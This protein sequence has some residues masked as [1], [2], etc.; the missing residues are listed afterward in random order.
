MQGKTPES[1]NLREYRRIF[2]GTNQ[3]GGYDKPF[4][5]FQAE[6]I[7]QYFLPDAYTYFHYP[8][9]A[10][11]MFLS[12]TSLVDMGAVPGLAPLYSDKIYKKMSGYGQF[13][14]WDN[15]QPYETG[16][17]LCAWLSGNPANAAQRPVWKDRWYDPGYVQNGPAL[18]AGSA[19]YIDNFPVVWDD[20]SIFTFDPGALYKYFH[21]GDNINE[22]F[23]NVLTADGAL[24]LHLEHWAET[25]PDDS[26]SENS[27]VIENYTPST[28]YFP[29]VNRFRT[30]DYC[31]SLN[32]T[33]QDCLV[34]YSSAFDLSSNLTVA[35]WAYAEDWSAVRGSH[36]V[37]AGLRGAWNIKYNNGFSNPFYVLMN[38]DDGNTVLMS[39]NDEVLVK[40]NIPGSPYP[41]MV[42]LDNRMYTWVIDNGSYQSQKHLYKMDY[43]GDIVLKVDFVSSCTL[44]S[45]ALDMS[46]NP[47]VLDSVGGISGFD[48][49]GTFLT[50]IST[51]YNGSVDFDLNGTLVKSNSPFVCVDNDNAIWEYS[52][53]DVLKDSFAVRSLSGVEAMSCDYE[54]NLWLL[55]DRNKFIKMDNLGVSL[56]SGTVGYAS[57]RRNL[58]FARK[59]VGGEYVDYV[60]IVQD[61]DSRVY[62]YDL[63]GTFIESVDLNPVTMDPSIGGDFTGYQWNRKFNYLRITEPIIE[64]EIILDFDTLSQQFY[65]IS[66][67]ATGLANANW[68]HFAFTYDSV[69]AE[70]KF[71]VDS[72]LVVSRAISPFSKIHYEYGSPIAI[73]ANMGRAVTMDEEM[74]SDSMHFGGRIDDV[75]L[76]ASTLNGSDVLNLYK[77][78]YD[79]EPVVWNM[80]VGQRGFVEEIERFFKFKV[81]GQKSQFY[82]IRLI[83]L[84]ITDTTVRSMIEDV[85][86]DTVQK[87]CPAYTELYKVIWE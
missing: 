1:V 55:Y 57:T 72:L 20:D 5:G 59:Y 78:K 43:N 69:N 12:A 60:Y 48:T 23:V 73:G 21:I 86:R 37:S 51:V 13:S 28:V 16:V 30:T 24:R 15:P 63:D 25:T 17:W 61:A 3:E 80:P 64:A 39:L 65:T 81:P 75:R 2:T 31:L 19:V 77:L 8:S 66:T 10:P 29:S 82:N 87:V 49:F 41:T 44:S 32:G 70:M 26:E 34:G 7:T 42:A 22:W 67:P 79:H 40:K 11:Q 47:W 68:H 74:H 18:S 54:G 53:T 50:A 84:N 83:G 76:Y 52:G 56:L 36:L 27:A 6:E 35:F 4:L 33:D 38:Q 71:Y 58:D 85:I 9:T 45:L 14:P 46:G 62:K